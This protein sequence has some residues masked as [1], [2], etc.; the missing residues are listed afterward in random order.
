MDI[1]E[2]G[3]TFTASETGFWTAR[4]K[5]LRIAFFGDFKTVFNK[6]RQQYLKAPVIDFEE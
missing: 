2:S 5:E 6:W 1:Q 3:F 4:N